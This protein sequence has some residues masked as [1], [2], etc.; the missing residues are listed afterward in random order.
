[1][2]QAHQTTSKKRLNS[3]RVDGT[4]YYA[5]NPR[6]SSGKCLA[7]GVIGRAVGGGRQRPPAPAPRRRTGPRPAAWGPWWRSRGSGCV[8][9]CWELPEFRSSY[10]ECPKYLTSVLGWG[11]PRLL[12]NG[13][14]PPLRP[15]KNPSRLKTPLILIHLCVAPLPFEELGPRLFASELALGI[16]IDATPV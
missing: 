14:H 9:P 5:Y 11:T 15:Q 12:R 3:S 10:L 2:I 7:D 6:K 13:L 16:R 1:M 4:R 8:A